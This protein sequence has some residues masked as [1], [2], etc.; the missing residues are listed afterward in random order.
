[1]DMQSIFFALDPFFI[2]PYRWISNPEMAVWMGSIVLGLWCV[3]AGEISSIFIY[4]VNRAYYA[5]LNAK[6]VRMHNLSIEAIKQ[7]DKA[8]F[9]AANTWAN[10]YFGKVFFAQAAFFAVSLWPVPFALGWMQTRFTGVDIVS[11]PMLSV[12]FDKFSLTNLSTDFISSTTVS[13]G[14]AF[15]LL[16]SYIALRYTLYKTRKYIPFLRN[17][18]AMREEDAELIN[19]IKSWDELNTSA[20]VTEAMQQPQED[21]ATAG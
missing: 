20:P 3:F 5:K 13:L 4:H 2:A 19:Q 1:M 14:Y 9:K 7:K 10:E 21:T 18:E 12:D 15:V 17:I 8:N 6:M 16:T 11:F